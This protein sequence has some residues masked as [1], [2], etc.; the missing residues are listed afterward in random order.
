VP[1]LASLALEMGRGGRRETRA[2]LVG[3][4]SLIRR[5][6]NAFMELAATLIRC[7]RS[8]SLSGMAS[9][10]RSAQGVLQSRRETFRGKEIDLVLLGQFLAC[11]CWRGF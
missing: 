1:L 6:N 3:C 2:F 11:R 9:A 10:Q 5:R 8:T 4:P 7:R